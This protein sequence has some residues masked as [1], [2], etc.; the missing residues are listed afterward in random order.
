VV[1]KPQ[2]ASAP[3]PKEQKRPLQSV[4]IFN[5]N[6]ITFSQKAI[7][8]NASNGDTCQR[9]WL[10]RQHFPSLDIMPPTLFSGLLNKQ[11]SGDNGFETKR[12][13]I[14]DECVNVLGDMP[15]KLVWGSKVVSAT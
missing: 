1:N 8:R 9:A 7:W 10:F 3:A 15:V 2:V 4:T 14:A 5:G 11:I 13:T 6:V 12:K